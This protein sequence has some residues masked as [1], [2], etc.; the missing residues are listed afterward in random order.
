[1]SGDGHGCV[2][3]AQ[4]LDGLVGEGVRMDDGG[5]VVMMWMGL[6]RFDPWTV[7]SLVFP[8]RL[9]VNA[10]W[11][12]GY[13]GYGGGYG[14]VEVGEDA[15]DDRCGLQI[16]HLGVGKD[17][18]WSEGEL[19]LWMMSGARYG[20]G[21]AEMWKRKKKQLPDDGSKAKKGK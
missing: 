13:D 7:Y 20:K 16:Q 3:D 14:E 5:F 1:M 21:G 15:I 19:P 9:T 2:F 18:C 4:L 17:P 12:G 10:V 6:F 11:R 8:L